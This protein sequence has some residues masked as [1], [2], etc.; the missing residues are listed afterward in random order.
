[1]S[2]VAEKFNVVIMKDKDKVDLTRG[3]TVQVKMSISWDHVCHKVLREVTVINFKCQ[4][5][6]PVPMLVK[7]G[8]HQN[9]DEDA[10]ARCDQHRLWLE[11]EILAHHPKK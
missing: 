3:L 2:P 1:M 6:T 7:G 4:Q 9:I 10:T 8:P 5:D 11:L